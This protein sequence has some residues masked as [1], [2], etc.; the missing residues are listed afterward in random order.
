M[1]SNLSKMKNIPSK[2]VTISDLM[3]TF[4]MS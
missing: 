4:A 2:A 3:L 1:L